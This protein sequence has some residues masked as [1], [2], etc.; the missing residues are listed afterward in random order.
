[1]I[2]DP[3]PQPLGLPVYVVIP[4]DGSP[5]AAFPDPYE[6]RHWASRWEE[7]QKLPYDVLEGRLI[8]FGTVT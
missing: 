1:M 2:R 5:R 3:G 4:R 8:I 7:E 6:A